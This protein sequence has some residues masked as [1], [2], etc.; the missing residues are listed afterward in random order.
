MRTEFF[1]ATWRPL[2][3]TSKYKNVDVPSEMPV[4]FDEMMNISMMLSKPFP[5]VRCDYYVVSGKLYF[6]EL[7]FTG[8]LQ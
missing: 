2:T 7:T 4:C 5:F 6:G 3:N 8:R 1:D